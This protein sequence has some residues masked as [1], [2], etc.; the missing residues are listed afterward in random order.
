MEWLSNS[1]LQCCWFRQRAVR[2][3]ILEPTQVAPQTQQKF[4]LRRQKK[5]SRIPLNSAQHGPQQLGYTSRLSSTN[6]SIIYTAEPQVGHEIS[7]L[8]QNLPFENHP[9]CWL[10]NTPWRH[11]PWRPQNQWLPPTLYRRCSTAPASFDISSDV[12]FCSLVYFFRFNNK[13]SRWS[14]IICKF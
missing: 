6:N 7:L 14:K 9:R 12:Q 10:V 5:Q 13:N 1:G 3:R 4:V 2:Q 11:L 8:T